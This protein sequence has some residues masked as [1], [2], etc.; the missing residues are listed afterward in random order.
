MSM[1]VTLD[2]K[3]KPGSGL[4]VSGSTQWWYYQQILAIENF[5]IE[6]SKQIGGTFKGA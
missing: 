2:I 5:Y 1:V 6:W 3:L 4:W